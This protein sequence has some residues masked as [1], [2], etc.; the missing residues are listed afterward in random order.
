[1]TPRAMG[2]RTGRAAFLCYHSIAEGGPPFLSLSPELFERQLA[3]LRRGGWAPGGRPTLDALASGRRLRTP[4][5]FLTFDDGYV[6]NFTSAFPLLREYGWSAIVFVL[7]D[8]VDREA[9]FAWPEVRGHVA[10]Y[11]EIMRSL[12]W[13]MVEEMAAAGIEFGSH[14]CSHA[15]LTRL[16]DEALRQELHDSRSRLRERLGRCDVLAYPF[17]EWDARVA[18]A[19]AAAGYRFAF[20]V[21]NGRGQ[22]DCILS[23]PRVAVDHRDGGARFSLKLSRSGR[24]IVLSPWRDALDGV[25]SRRNGPQPS[26]PPAAAAVADGSGSATTSGALC[27]R[28]SGRS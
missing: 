9:E 1:M 24:R 10:A 11:P 19:A 6:D 12:S 2:N 5:V 8:L 13:P 21:R 14:T 4:H 26:G 18:D 3:A 28:E 27:D 7:P 20:S 15:H 25:R 16:G 23:I 22:R 17:G